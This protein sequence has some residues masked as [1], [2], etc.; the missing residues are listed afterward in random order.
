MPEG[1][2]GQ[3]GTGG[4][5]G[6]QTQPTQPGTGTA[7]NPA[8]GDIRT[9]TQDQV[10]SFLA[11]EKRKW[12]VDR[13]AAAEAAR[14]TEQG[15]H[16]ELAEQ[17]KGQ[18]TAAQREIRDTR[19]ESL[20]TRLAHKPELNIVDAEAALRLLDTSVV[21]WNEDRPDAASV[22]EA[23]KALI[24]ARPFLVAGPPTTPRGG[25]TNP[26]KP[27]ATTTFTRKQ[28]E[29]ASFFKAHRAEIMAAMKEGRITED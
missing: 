24:K 13:D 27:A 21:K 23:L 10:N 16:K 9:F 28:L 29:D 14:L 8:A 25:A 11:E 20:V 4:D 3:A 12:Q 7:P 5:P 19:L 2:T 15:K 17:L 26:A 18:L 22:E 1:T 6:T